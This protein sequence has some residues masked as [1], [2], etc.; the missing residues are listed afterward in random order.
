MCEQCLS[1]PGAP[2]LIRSGGGEAM[3][4]FSLCSTGVPPKVTSPIEMPV[5]DSEGLF[6]VQGAGT[7]GAG[8]GLGRLLF[9]KI[10]VTR[11]R[12]DIL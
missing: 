5:S 11:K 7:E 9:I 8:E 1:T 12:D 4:P 10:N 6:G 2:L 3:S